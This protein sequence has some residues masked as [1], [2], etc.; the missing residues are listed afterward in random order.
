MELS[1]EQMMQRIALGICL[2]CSSTALVFRPWRKRIGFVKQEAYC[3][4]CGARWVSVYELEGA[5]II[6]GPTNE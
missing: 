6:N 5:E 4:T 1:T 3:K 2:F